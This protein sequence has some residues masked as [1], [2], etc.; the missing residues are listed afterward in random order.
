MCVNTH[1]NDCVRRYI[2]K[3]TNNPI[4]K[5][6]SNR[7]LKYFIEV[8]E[9]SVKG[10][11]RV[12]TKRAY[13]IGGDTGRD[14]EHGEWFFATWLTRVYDGTRWTREGQERQLSH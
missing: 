13:Y 14:V 6:K 3:F 2:Y 9:R 5:K 8:T 12:A 1:L 4:K 10:W 11:Q 7:K